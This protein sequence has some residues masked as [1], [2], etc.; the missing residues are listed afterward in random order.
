LLKQEEGFAEDRIASQQRRAQ[1]AEAVLSPGVVMVALLQ[2]C[3][4]RASVYHYGLHGLC[5]P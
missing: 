4:Q 1:L 5:E 2:V 3:S